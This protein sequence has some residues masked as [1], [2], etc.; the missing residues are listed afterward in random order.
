MPEQWTPEDRAERLLQVEEA[1]RDADLGEMWDGIP[2]EKQRTVVNAI[3]F[4]ADTFATTFDA[5]LENTVSRIRQ[6]IDDLPGVEGTEITG[7]N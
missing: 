4:A 7:E 3:R 6:G 2:G 5:M 1:F